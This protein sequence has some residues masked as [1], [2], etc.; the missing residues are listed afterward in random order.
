M[1]NGSNN[2]GAQSMRCL[3]LSRSSRLVALI[4]VLLVASSCARDSHQ[5]V[6]NATFLF[7][8]GE[9]YSVVILEPT[10]LSRM[11]G[12]R[13]QQRRLYYGY[14]GGFD[15]EGAELVTPAEPLAMLAIHSP[16]M[17][18]GGNRG[19][20]NLSV[21]IYDARTG[22]QVMISLDMV[23]PGISVISPLRKRTG[24]A[25]ER[26]LEDGRLTFR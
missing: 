21:L 26:W 24:R 14:S 13:W 9:R 2:T 10:F 18:I 22:E 20:S 16:V 8:H 17:V 11:F 19:N 1:T 15:E 3:L 5:R 4:L 23:K 7:P 6:E 12:P 25:Q